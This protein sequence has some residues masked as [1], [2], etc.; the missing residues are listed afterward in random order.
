MDRPFYYFREHYYIL[1]YESCCLLCGV[2][3]L[4]IYTVWDGK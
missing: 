4:R 3:H 2:W 1:F